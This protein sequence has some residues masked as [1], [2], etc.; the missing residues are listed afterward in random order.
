MSPPAQAG[1]TA[2]APMIRDIQCHLAISFSCRTIVWLVRIRSTV[3]QGAP[4]AFLYATRRLRLCPPGL[5]DHCQRICDP[6][7]ILPQAP[8]QKIDEGARL[9]REMSVGRIDRLDDR[10]VRPE[11]RQEVDQ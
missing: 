11:F 8:D 2:D 9:R 7:G 3:K 6:V 1:R 5:P 10:L 4:S